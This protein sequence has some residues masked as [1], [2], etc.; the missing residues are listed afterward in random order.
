[1]RYLRAVVIVVVIAAAVS[2]GYV[3]LSQSTASNADAER[4]EPK[5]D[6]TLDRFDTLAQAAAAAGFD[7]PDIGATGWQ[8]VPDRAFV[9]KRTMGSMTQVVVLI[10]YRNEPTGDAFELSVLTQPVPASALGGQPREVEL[11]SGLSVL[12]LLEPGDDTVPRQISATWNE[13]GR[14]YT[15][16]G[17]TSDTLSADE[18]LEIIDSLE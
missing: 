10:N 8:F 7:L 4:P 2:L 11:A 13:D 6:S 3:A 18:F 14:G 9:G 16:I 17:I 5:L 12:I 15:A 1:M